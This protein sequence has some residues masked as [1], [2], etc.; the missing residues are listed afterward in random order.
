[1]TESGSNI[2]SDLGQPSNA[3]AESSTPERNIEVLHFEDTDV[4]L[5]TNA[6]LVIWGHKLAD[7]FKDGPEPEGWEPIEGGILRGEVDGKLFVVKQ[8][9]HGRDASELEGYMRRHSSMSEDEQAAVKKTF[10][11]WNSVLSE[12][13]VAP[14]VKRLLEDDEAQEIVKQAGFNGISYTE[15]ILGV[16]TRTGDGETKKALVYE[17]IENQGHLNYTALQSEYGIDED[18]RRWLVN[19]LHDYFREHHV[20]PGDSGMRHILFD[21]ELNLHLIDAEA[22][23]PDVDLPFGPSD[24]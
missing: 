11:S 21:S 14:K 3:K 19:K 22:Y 7:V 2:E 24:D 16:V 10:Y 15:P 17:Y 12:L 23:I 5:N 20:F 9:Q 18:H 6:D 1:M 4:I 8:K 13:T